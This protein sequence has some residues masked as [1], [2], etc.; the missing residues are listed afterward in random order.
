MDTHA[1]AP[2]AVRPEPIA[3]AT[4]DWG[5][6]SYTAALEQQEALVARRIAGEA[7]DTLVFTEHDPVFTVGVRRGAEANLLW[8]AAEL[9]RRGIAVVTT[10]RGGDITYHGPGQIVGYPIISL[11]PR[12]DLHAYLRFL[13]Q[14]IIN[15][16]GTFK[17]PFRA[18]VVVAQPI[19]PGSATGGGVAVGQVYSQAGDPSPLFQPD[20]PLANADGHV[21]A[22]V[23]DLAGQMSDLILASRMYQANISVHKEA[24]EALESA[25][26]LGK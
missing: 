26:T 24:R 7:G 13:E 12:K 1:A 11:A 17:D 15:T 4:L 21:A 2:A 5:R 9:Q 18:R 10:S 20:S 23:V 8:D 6:T 19:D 16:V 25:T 22:P 14:V 3:G